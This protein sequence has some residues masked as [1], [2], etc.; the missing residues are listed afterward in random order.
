MSALCFQAVQKKE[1]R[2]TV[3]K[4]DHKPARIKVLSEVL[5]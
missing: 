5:T 2:S 1:G 3:M 4:K